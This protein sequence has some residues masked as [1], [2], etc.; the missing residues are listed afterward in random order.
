MAEIIEIIISEKESI[1]KILGEEIEV[2]FQNFL[3]EFCYGGRR[4]EL[5]NNTAKWLDIEAAKKILPYKSKKKWKELRE[6][7]EVEFAKVGRGFFYEFHSLHNYI[8]K[9]STITKSTKR[10]SKRK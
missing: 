5:S 3:R 2:R 7:A 8:I 9:Q 10:A 1:R 4:E 6:M